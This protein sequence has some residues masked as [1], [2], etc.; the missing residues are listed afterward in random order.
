MKVVISI[1]RYQVLIDYEKQKIEQTSSL[2]ASC[3]DTETDHKKH[4]NFLEVIFHEVEEGHSH[5]E[6]HGKIKLNYFT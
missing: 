6:D 2:R 4:E 3:T 1:N 5:S